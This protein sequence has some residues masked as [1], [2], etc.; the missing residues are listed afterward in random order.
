MESAAQTTRAI[1]E[2][3]TIT[4]GPAPTPTRTPTPTPTP[5]TD[6][7]TVSVP[8]TVRVGRAVKFVRSRGKRTSAMRWR[9]CLCVLS[10]RLQL[11]RWCATCDPTTR[12]RKC[13]RA[14]TAKAMASIALPC[15]SFAHTR[16]CLPLPL[17]FSA[18]GSA[19]ASPRCSSR[20]RQLPPSLMHLRLRQLTLVVPHWHPGHPHRR[21]RRRRHRP[22]LAPPPPPPRASRWTCSWNDRWTR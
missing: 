7:E 13:R 2:T 21:R 15:L 1:A 10:P 3:K 4:T 5:M 19:Q 12:G 8:I 14:V 9:V 20:V 6:D 17:F 22:L 11:F 18:C 16:T